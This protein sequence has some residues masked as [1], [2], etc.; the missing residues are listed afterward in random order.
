MLLHNGGLKM[1]LRKKSSYLETN[2]TETHQHR[3]TGHNGRSPNE[4]G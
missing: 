3:S 2:D 4:A 1:K